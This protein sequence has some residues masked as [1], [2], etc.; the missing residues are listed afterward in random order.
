MARNEN[1]SLA[2][3]PETVFH[4][5]HHRQRIEIEAAGIFGRLADDLA[6]LRG[7][8]DEIVKLVRQSSEDELRH[9]RYC[10]DILSFS[11]KSFTPPPPNVSFDLGPAGL[12]REDR[13]IYTCVAACCITETLSTALL[14]DMYKKAARGVI[15]ETVYKILADEVTHSRIGWAELARVSKTRNL[16]WVS[17]YVPQMIHAALVSDVGPVLNRTDAQ[18]DLS[19]WGILSPFRAKEI[20]TEAMTTIIV[21]GLSRFGIEARFDEKEMGE[22]RNA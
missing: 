18:A 22:L 19:M 13:I 12:N 16:N 5:W 9:A 7:G 4:V 21:P 15:K 6:D 11:R 20:M 1:L 3:A 17:S 10:Q 8:D 14:V 2:A